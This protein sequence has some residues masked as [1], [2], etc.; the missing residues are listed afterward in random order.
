MPSPPADAFQ[1][2]PI[3]GVL[4]RRIFGTGPVLLALLFFVQPAGAAAQLPP[5]PPTLPPPFPQPESPLTPLP[6]SSRAQDAVA[7]RINVGHSGTSADDS[8]IPPLRQRWSRNLHGLV[9]YPLIAAGRV[10]AAVPGKHAARVI[11]LDR[12]S[13]RARWSKQIAHSKYYA[14]IVM[15]YGGG[16]LFA[17][18]PSGYVAALDAATGDI[19]W[20]RVLS[21]RNLR[22]EDPPIVAG[23]LLVVSSLPE[24]SNSDAGRVRAIHTSDGTLAW[25]QGVTGLPASDGT[26]IILGTSCG[27]AAA[28]RP[29]DGAL[30]WS[31]PPP[32]SGGFNSKLLVDRGRVY[33]VD[34]MSNSVLRADSGNRIFDLGRPDPVAVWRDVAL[35]QDT[36]ESGV[37]ARDSGT[38]RRLWYFGAGYTCFGLCSPPVVSGRFVYMADQGKLWALELYSGRDRWH[39][40]LTASYTPDWRS[41]SEMA[42]GDGIL[43][44]PDG[45]RLRAYSSVLQPPPNGSDEDTS[46]SY[47][48]FGDSTRLFGAVGHNLRDGG[49]HPVALEADR[50]PYGQ[51]H[52]ADR[53]T[54]RPDGTFAFRVRPSR[55]TRYR[56]RAG[57]NA[58]PS[59]GG[60]VFVLPRFKDRYLRG[61]GSQINRITAYVR[62]LTPPDVAL[63]GREI[64]LY[65]VR[66]GRK[67]VIR[68][69]SGRLHR[70]G[71]GK[72]SAT[73]QFEAVKGL[74][75][76]DYA[77]YCIRNLSPI[78]MGPRDVV[79]SRCGRSRLPYR[80]E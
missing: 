63:G 2:N 27:G 7:Y 80:A 65:L 53:T 31:R 3:Y 59:T 68:L 72:A 57:E 48:A 6:S 49:R 17:V 66:V 20:A 61:S 22:Y 52:V 8:L 76:R 29:S 35:T 39:S 25:E 30:L 70:R 33:T 43:A 60:T 77:F 79:D 42:V 16:R 28:Y 64:H 24:N 69:S 15:A 75:P 1:I 71:R 45:T 54:S 10:F 51:F 58:P 9:S 14:D 56:T 38:G 47:L 78:G 19:L 44:V 40:R 18:S 37:F 12:A 34:T 36:R 13:G 62:A 5:L 32:C 21:G 26:R 73:L 74:R 4:M 67:Q 46:D 23:S 50:F 11:A 41:L 55:N